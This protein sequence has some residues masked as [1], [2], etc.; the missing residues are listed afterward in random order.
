MFAPLLA[1]GFQDFVW[2]IV[3]LFAIGSGVVNWFKEKMQQS[4]QREEQ[5][6]R[7]SG[8]GEP[9]TSSDP[10]QSEIEAFLQQVSTSQK[11]SSAR[12]VPVQ[13]VEE[14]D[15]FYEDEPRPQK[16]RQQKQK[17]TQKQRP[18]EPV[19]NRHLSSTGLGQVANRHVKS[20]V[21]EHHLSS[22]VEQ[23]HLTSQVGGGAAIGS[24]QMADSSPLAGLFESADDTRRAII[25]SEVLSPPLC[26]RK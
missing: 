13:Q 17:Q 1:A 4:R 6:Q 10:L 25:L 20:Q 14:A 5:E 9:V 24:G 16:K 23:S 26:R 11:P 18:A 22:Q 19:A 3:I 15:A 2:L 7:R 8:M 12:P 21:K